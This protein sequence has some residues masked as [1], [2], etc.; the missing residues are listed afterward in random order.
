MLLPMREQPTVRTHPS[1]QHNPTIP[2][3]PSA[4]AELTHLWLSML[5][6]DS[7]QPWMR[8]TATPGT[9]P[10]DTPP[11]DPSC[12]WPGALT[13]LELALLL[14]CRW[15]PESAAAAAWPLG[16]L[17]RLLTPSCC[18]GCTG[19]CMCTC[20]RLLLLRPLNAATN[21][22]PLLL[23]LLPLLLLPTPPSLRV[24]PPPLVVCVLLLLPAWEL[25]L[26]AV[27]CDASKS[28]KI[29]SSSESSSGGSGGL[30]SVLSWSRATALVLLRWMAP[31]ECC[32]ESVAACRRHSRSRN[33][34]SH[35]QHHSATNSCC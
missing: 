24:L 33:R 25:L 13:L 28:A 12:L 20:F 1:P 2:S 18:A 35:T 11:S 27:K 19:S 9:T 21:L 3:P 30:L 34:Q 31:P 26:P 6:C 15:G 22:L 17:T 7:Q 4:P 32:A 29:A 5:R 23:G 14:R 8:A 10:G 16:A